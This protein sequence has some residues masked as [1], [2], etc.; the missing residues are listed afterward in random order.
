MIILLLSKKREICLF[1]YLKKIEFN[2]C[3]PFLGQENV[4]VFLINSYKGTFVNQAN[5]SINYW[6][7][8]SSFIDRYLNF[9]FNLINIA[10][11]SKFSLILKYVH[12][13]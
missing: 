9:L 6:L 1:F 3:L 10:E 7:L 5:K 11:S 8:N 13:C 12:L 2:R 4:V